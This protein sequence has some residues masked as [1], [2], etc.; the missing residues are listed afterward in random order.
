MS[1]ISVTGTRRRLASAVLVAVLAAASGIGMTVLPGL[2]SAQGTTCVA[3]GATGLTTVEVAHTGQTLTGSINAAAC[4]MGIFVGPDTSNVTING[5]TITGAKN[6]AILV[7]NASDVVIEN[8]TIVGNGTKPETCPGGGAPAKAPCI[9]ENKPVE[10]VG[11]TNSVVKDNLVANNHSDGGIGI[12]DDGKTDPGGLSAGIAHASTGNVVEGNTIADNAAGC[13]VVVAAYNPGAG[14]S[15]NRVVDNTVVGNVAGIVVAADSP[16]TVAARNVVQ[17]N[18]ITGNFLPGVIV[19]A[20]TPG[21][22][23]SGTVIEGNVIA[24]NGGDKGADAGRGPA[25]AT[26]IVVVAEPRPK[27][28][29]PGLPNAALK[30]TLIQGN[31]IGGEAAALFTANATG[32]VLGVNTIVKSATVLGLHA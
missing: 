5:V 18:T 6:H 7:Q 10:L 4:D 13:G 14:V 25:G 11:T 26:A 15:G 20:N 9:A 28:F 12:A 23:V 1:R 3:A 32:T 16:A 8:S 17:D 31:T 21:D 2:A 27:G 24:H 29:P 19:H 22:M 30:G